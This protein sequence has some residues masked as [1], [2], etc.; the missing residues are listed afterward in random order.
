MSIGIFYVKGVDNTHRH[1]SIGKLKQLT[2]KEAPLI[3]QEINEL[4]ASGIESIYIDASNVVHA[5][6]S[7]INEVIHANYVLNEMSKKLVLAYK[8]H[9]VIDKWV[10]TTGLDRFVE[11]AI[12]LTN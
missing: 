8:Q 1:L 5:D 10:Q 2:S 11:T 9:S 6:L 4:V 12:I 3:R 7:G